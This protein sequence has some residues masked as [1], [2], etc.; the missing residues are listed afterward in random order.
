M[1]QGKASVVTDEIDTFT[2]QGVKLRSGRELEADLIVTATGLNLLLLGGLEV[3]VDGRRVDF[4]LRDSG[5]AGPP[6]A[7]VVTA[8]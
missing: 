1:Q 5:G 4:A 8:P 2:E 3:T 7:T 6:A